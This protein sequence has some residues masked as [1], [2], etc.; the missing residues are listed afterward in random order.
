MMG[1]LLLHLIADGLGWVRPCVCSPRSLSLLSFACPT[2]VACFR[3]VFL[4]KNVINAVPKIGTRV[5]FK[6]GIDEKGA[7]KAEEATVV[8]TGVAEGVANGGA[9]GNAS[10]AAAAPPRAAGA[11][12]APLI[13]RA[14]LM[15]SRGDQVLVARE[16]KDDKLLWSDLGGKVEEG[17]SLLE[18]ALR[19]M[20]EEAAGF[21]SPASLSL[22][23]LG[24]RQRY[25]GDNCGPEVV[26]LRS[27][28]SR[29]QD[30]QCFIRAAPVV[31]VRSGSAWCCEQSWSER[32]SCWGRV[33]PG[34]GIRSA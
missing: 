4:H 24:L 30:V 6:L 2:V 15:I 7:P 5:A 21:I 10:A 31:I 28:G 33:A 29:P 1:P 17:E 22:L 19:E 16:M 27:G 20:A 8:T 9:E 18:C 11:A 14:A 34:V 13:K 32:P 23:Q 12:G 26:T 3:D 25:G